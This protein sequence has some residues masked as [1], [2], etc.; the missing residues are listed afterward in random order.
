MIVVVRFALLRVPGCS[1]FESFGTGSKIA[2]ARLFGKRFQM[3]KIAAFAERKGGISAGRNA[4][5]GSRK[6]CCVAIR[7]VIINDKHS[8]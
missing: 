6:I 4:R 8:Q 1:L 3:K 2:A 7:A 5:L